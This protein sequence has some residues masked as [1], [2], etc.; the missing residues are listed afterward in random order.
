M[1]L[2][3]S[4]RMAP[5]NHDTRQPYE[6]TVFFLRKIQHKSRLASTDYSSW[7]SFYARGADHCYISQ[8]EGEI[9]A[10]KF[11]DR[12]IRNRLQHALGEPCEVF[13]ADEWDKHLAILEAITERIVF[14]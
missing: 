13:N 6:D 4:S 9:E 11:F 5:R 3:R 7:F 14:Y 1:T 10:V 8:N 12:F 2:T